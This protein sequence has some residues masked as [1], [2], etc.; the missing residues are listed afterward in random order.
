MVDPQSFMEG[1]MVRIDGPMSFRLFV[2][3]L[4]ALFFGIRDGR[5]DAR[6]GA[7]PYFWAMATNGDHRRD[8]LKGGWKSIGKVFILAV[9]LD[10]IFQYLTF[11]AFHFLGA[12]V[13]GVVLALVP[14]LLLRSIVNRLLHDSS[15]RSDL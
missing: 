3:P 13:A 10:L 14:Y 5:S 11:S 15:A 6:A 2:Q 12:L 1:L 9:V 4:V 8:M 7:P